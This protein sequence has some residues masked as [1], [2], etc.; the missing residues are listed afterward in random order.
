LG[1]VDTV[2]VVV[3]GFDGLTLTVVGAVTCGGLDAPALTGGG[4]VPAGG[5][6]AAAGSA[7]AADNSTASPSEP[8]TEL[9]DGR[10]IQHLHTV[11]L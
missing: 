5:T 6:W 4:L 3:V 10:R 11:R 7:S 2:D 1:A 8:V 9:K